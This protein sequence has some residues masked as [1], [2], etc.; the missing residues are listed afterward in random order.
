M[1]DLEL[2]EN[3]LNGQLSA[4]DKTRFEAALRTDS[5]VADALAFYVLARHTAKTDAREQR[6]AELD[7]LRR[8]PDVQPVAELPSEVPVR[9]LWGAP[10]RWAAAASVV[11]LLGLGWYFLRDT[12]GSSGGAASGEMAVNA[13][14]AYINKE[15]GQLSTT[16]GGSSDSLRQGVGLYNDGKL[17]QAETIFEDVLTRQPDNENALK[18]AGIVALRRGNY[19][20]AISRFHRLS[21]RT[22]LVSN[23]GTFY[24][25]LAYLKRG[26][27]VDKE[28]ARKLL[29]AVINKNLEG[30]SEAERL[31]EKW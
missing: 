20:Q 12:I 21:Q 2:I 16:M 13:A 29:D 22:D 26:R 24:E 8:R 4:E 30:K 14:D 11:L 17:K 23:P 28:Q 27:P 25:A 1:N 31:V 7:A 15:F 9:P 6:R 5:T 10:M 3:Y 18:Y 19:D